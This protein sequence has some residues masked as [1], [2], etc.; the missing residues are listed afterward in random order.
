[1]RVCVVRLGGMGDILLA[2][3][4]LRALAA[5]FPGSTIDF[6]VGPGME[7]AVTGL[8]YAGRILAFDRKKHWGKGLPG[9]VKTL[10]ADGRYDLFLNFQP[11]LKTLTLMALSQ[12]QQTIVFKKDR[13]KQA[14]TGRVRHAI[15]DFAKELVPLGI[16]VTDRQLDFFVPEAARESLAAK[17]DLSVPY[18]A[19]NPAGTRDINRWPP[20]R[21]AELIERLVG[22]GRRVLL[23][24][25]PGDL[26]L[27]SEIAGKTQAPVENL[28]GKLTVKELGALLERATCVVTGDT[29]PL[30]IASAVKAPIVCLSGAADPDRTGPTRPGD[31]VVINRELS[32][33]PCQARSC[34]R[35]DIACMTQL[36]VDGVWDAIERRIR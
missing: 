8:P 29:G 18:I 12:P 15:D 34:K 36:P 3:P 21:F 25:G 6:V 28:A 20:E 11:S 23:L 17:L 5:H 30:H 7:A 26:A 2:T 35:G 32:C 27:A 19:I 16:T 4:T 31:L 24:G 33:V 14:A 10:R 1:M 13:R 9:F 22:A